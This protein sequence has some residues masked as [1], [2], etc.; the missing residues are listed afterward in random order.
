MAGTGAGEPYPS[1]FFK[2]REKGFPTGAETGEEKDQTESE[3]GGGAVEMPVDSST[4]A[5]PTSG[6][7]VLSGGHLAPAAVF[8]KEKSEEYRPGG[9]KVRS[10]RQGPYGKRG[11]INLLNLTVRQGASGRAAATKNGSARRE[12]AEPPVSCTSLCGEISLCPDL[13]GY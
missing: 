9:R 3:R 13:S 12:P 8:C 5:C 4:G 7:S 1:L 10:G 6:K 11:L 2:G